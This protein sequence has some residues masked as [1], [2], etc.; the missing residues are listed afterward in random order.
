[1]AGDPYGRARQDSALEGEILAELIADEESTK[2][3][4]A[5]IDRATRLKADVTQRLAVTEDNLAS[6]N[7]P[8]AGSSRSQGQN[9]VKNRVFSVNLKPVKVELPKLE[10]QKFSGKLEEWQEFWDSFESAIHSN[11]VNSYN[12]FLIW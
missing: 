2:E 6:T 4:T 7:M 9:I 1:M 11:R 12:P 10:V 3:V 8:C 5:E